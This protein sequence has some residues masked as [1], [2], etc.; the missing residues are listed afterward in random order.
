LD[1]FWRGWFYTVDHVDLALAEVDEYKRVS[2][3]IGEE[4]EEEAPME[5][6]SS[7]KKKKKKKKKE[8]PV[9]EE[10]AKEQK[11][12]K[13]FYALMFPEQY[14]RA[15][16]DQLY[17]QLKLKNEGGLVMPV[18]LEFQYEDG[19]SKEYRIPAEIWKYN[20][21]EITKVFPSMKKVT[22]IILDPNKETADTDTSNNVWPP[23][24]EESRFQ[25]FK[26]GQ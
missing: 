1:W 25:Q 13:E 19:S 8:E 10:P 18:I 9:V 15:P 14:Q 6:E 22:K 3:P 24:T 16:D 21:E 5:E 26:E 11:K 20:D 2:Q 7:K 23:E 12:T 17:Y 4:V